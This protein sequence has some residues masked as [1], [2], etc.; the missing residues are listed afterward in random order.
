MVR[1]NSLISLDVNQSA[2][3]SPLPPIYT[4]SRA[5]EKLLGFPDNNQVSYYFIFIPNTKHQK[6]TG[7]KH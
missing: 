1:N 7:R 6:S 5:V 3:L 4:Y 2:V